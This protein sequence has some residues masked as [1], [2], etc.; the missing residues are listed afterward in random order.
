MGNLLCCYPRTDS[1]WSRLRE[2]KEGKGKN[3]EYYKIY[4][5]LLKKN[6]EICPNCKIGTI[7]NKTIHCKICHHLINVVGL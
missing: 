1:I 7:N 6:E 5:K 3:T 2:G 4:P